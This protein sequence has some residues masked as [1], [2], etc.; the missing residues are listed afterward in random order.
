MELFLTVFIS[1]AAVFLIY[2]GYRRILS[3]F[4]RR[5]IEEN[6]DILLFGNDFI[7]YAS[8]ESLEYYIRAALFFGGE[9]NIIINIERA[10]KQ[11][12]DMYETARIFAGKNTNI[13]INYI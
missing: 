11:S 9:T 5:D 7:I 3:H 13:K 12:A 4:L 10:T 8:P 2:S 6:E 1:A